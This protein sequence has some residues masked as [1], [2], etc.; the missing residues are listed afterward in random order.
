MTTIPS[1]MTTP[2]PSCMGV[3][4][5]GH[6]QF[7]CQRCNGTGVDWQATAERLAEEHEDLKNG[8]RELRDK[9]GTNCLLARE[10]ENRGLHSGIGVS[11]AWD[12]FE[13]ALT[14]LIS[15]D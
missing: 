7:P 15:E 2:C 14:D 10:E 13:D 5:L 6:Y 8:V 9:A 1:R 11:N 12:V 3:G 4:K